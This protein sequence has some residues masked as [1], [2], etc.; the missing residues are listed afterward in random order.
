MNDMVSFS[1][2]IYKVNYNE[3]EEIIEYY[4]NSDLGDTSFLNILGMLK[5][6]RCDFKKAKEIFEVSYATD[7]NK[8]A[9][10]YLRRFNETDQYML[11]CTAVE[12][13]ENENYN[14]ALDIL[15]VLNRLRE[16]FL[17]ATA[18]TILLYN[19]EGKFLKALKEI[20]RAEEVFG[21]VEKLTPLKKSIK[22]KLL[23][24]V[25]HGV[26]AAIVVLGMYFSLQ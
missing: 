15:E 20:E 12:D 14:E 19:H 16:E 1:N 4:I 8:K 6:R 17:P 24:S 13:C 3:V 26:F 5:F 10:E 11:Y 21:E 18:L 2:H 7:R 9:L 22:R 23:L 25:F